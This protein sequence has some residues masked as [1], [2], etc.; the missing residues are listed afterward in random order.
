MAR[1]VRAV[2]PIDA[3]ATVI[4]AVAVSTTTQG[5]HPGG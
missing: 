5:R 4:A 3:V 1:R 2:A